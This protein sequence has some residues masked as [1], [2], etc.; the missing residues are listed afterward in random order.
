MARPY[1]IL[2]MC[3]NHCGCPTRYPDL[4]RL[5]LPVRPSFMVC[6][7]CVPWALRHAISIED[8]RPPFDPQ[9]N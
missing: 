3:C 9:L 5:I 6:P 7:D 4:R 8:P 1:V 2:K